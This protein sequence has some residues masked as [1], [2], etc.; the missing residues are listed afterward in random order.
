MFASK[1]AHVVEKV[2]KRLL[3]IINLMKRPWIIFYEAWF[4]KHCVEFSKVLHV[5]IWANVLLLVS[6]YRTPFCGSTLA[7]CK[8]NMHATIGKKS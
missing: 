6:A 1:E 2:G 7:I 8:F 4:A 5:V 3:S